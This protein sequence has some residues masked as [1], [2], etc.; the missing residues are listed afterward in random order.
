MPATRGGS[1]SQPRA[2]FTAGKTNQI[3]DSRT[4]GERMTNRELRANRMAPPETEQTT[5]V[6]RVVHHLVTEVARVHRGE[7]G[8]LPAHPYSAEELAAA[9][10]KWKRLLDLIIVALLFPIWL[11]VMTLIALWVAVTSPGPI[12][13]RQPRIG[14]KGRRF[15]L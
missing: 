4:T 10:P 1:V 8:S 13:Y 5:E 2:A 6:T 12:F 3:M 7:S 15:M 11:P 9:L 14:F